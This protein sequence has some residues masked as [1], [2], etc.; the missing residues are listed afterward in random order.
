MAVRIVLDTNILVSACWKP[1]GNEAEVARLA[2]TGIIT[3]CVSAATLAE[4]RDVLSRRKLS[5]ISAAARELL[6]SL[7]QAA[8][9]FEPTVETGAPV[10]ASVDEDDNRFLECA[11]AARAEFLITGNLRH[12]PE[13][14]GAARI[15]NARTFLSLRY[16][17]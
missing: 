10:R 14:W 13:V 3:P 12:Y 8:L 2:T 6:A 16:R 4:Y 17:E 15:V 7:E 9:V 1:G 5:G 11:D